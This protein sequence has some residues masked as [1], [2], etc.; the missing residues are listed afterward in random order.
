MNVNYTPDYLYDLPQQRG[1]PKIECNLYK[2]KST[3]FD[4]LREE[5]NT[6]SDKCEV[7]PSVIIHDNIE[8]TGAVIITL[9]FVAILLNNKR[10]YDMIKKKKI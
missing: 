6:L 3:M 1:E 9:E 5:V 7:P 4:S 8:K 10:V 2:D